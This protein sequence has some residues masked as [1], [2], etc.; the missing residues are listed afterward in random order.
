LLLSFSFNACLLFYLLV[1]VGEI[2]FICSLF[3]SW[4]V[5]LLTTILLFNFSWF[6]FSWCSTLCNIILHLFGIDEFYFM[7]LYFFFILC[8]SWF[9]C[10]FFGLIFLFYFQLVFVFLVVLLLENH[11]LRFWF[12]VFGIGYFVDAIWVALFGFLLYYNIYY[13][14]S[15]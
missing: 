2:A 8:F 12:L 14:V 15:L 11:L 1:F 5:L 3:R 10:S 13:P 6:L 7:V 4:F 9:T